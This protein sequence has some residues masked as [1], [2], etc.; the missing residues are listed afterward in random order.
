MEE[1]HA[2]KILFDN[3]TW[4]DAAAETSGIVAAEKTGDYGGGV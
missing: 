3:I 1:C 2:T 4:G